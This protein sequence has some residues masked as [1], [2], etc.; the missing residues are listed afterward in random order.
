MG[1]LDQ[2]L[3]EV[4]GPAR[5]VLSPSVWRRLMDWARATDFEVSGMG[6]L[7]VDGD[8][9]RLTETFL[10]PQLANEL[11]TQLDPAGLAALVVDLVGRD[12]D[13]AA[14]R[15]WWHSHA[16]ETPFWSGL[17]ER[18]IQGFAPVTMVSLV[19]DH[20]GRRLAR[21][22]AFA[23]RRTK[24]LDVAEVGPSGDATADAAPDPEAARVE[25]EQA[26]G[27]LGG[28]PA[29]LQIGRGH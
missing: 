17:D 16:R 9:L 5:L 12:R 23:P 21:L 3:D 1:I 8:D 2:R 29:R 4:D 24:L 6:I 7:A 18:T 13:P 25:V 15:V 22:D 14:L 28:E 11:E 26:V 20:R 27:A 19:V 10:L